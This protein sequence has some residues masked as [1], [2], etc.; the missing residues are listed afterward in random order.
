MKTI[1]T[2]CA[3][4]CQDACGIDADVED[5]R[6][7]RLRGAQDHPYTEGFL[8]IRLNRFL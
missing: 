7:V 4:D 6:V 5:G 3:L 8:C 1:R 2:T